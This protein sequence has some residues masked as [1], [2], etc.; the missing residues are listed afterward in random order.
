VISVAFGLAATVL[1]PGQSTFAPSNTWTFR[2]P[3]IGF[4][5]L[6]AAVAAAA[7]R[8]RRVAAVALGIAALQGPAY[9]VHL[10]V[11]D[12]LRAADRSPWTHDFRAPEARVS[13]RGLPR[14]RVLPG[15]RLALWPGAGDRMR[16]ARNAT[17]DFADAG[18]LLVTTWTKQRTMQELIAPNDLLFNQMTELPPAILCDVNAVRFLQLR[19]LLFP[20]NEECSPWS[21]LADV[22]VD[23]WL[24]VGIAERDDRVRALPAAAATESIRREPALTTQSR[25]LSAL[26]PLPGTSLLITARAVVIRLDDPSV[27]RG[28]VLVLPVAYDAAWR[29]SSGGV[30]KIGGL[31]ALA[32]VDQT[33]VTLEFVPDQVAMA[34]AFSMTLAQILTVVGLLGLA[35]LHA[36]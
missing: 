18:Y 5:V 22:K 26:A 29:A 17:A 15:G 35:S 7:V 4:A 21:P 30:E 9:A 1:F 20:G 33:V 27:A 19:Y 13:A 6:G 25:L 36:A 28:Q 31:V 2:D 32:G 12:L 23:G 8:K 11:T 16:N 14:E 3:A 10:V 34:R 24:H